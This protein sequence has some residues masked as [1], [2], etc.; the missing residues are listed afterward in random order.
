MD[1][2]H[3]KQIGEDTRTLTLTLPKKKPD[4]AVPVVELF[5]K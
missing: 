3:A 1:E 2:W 4:V 5:L